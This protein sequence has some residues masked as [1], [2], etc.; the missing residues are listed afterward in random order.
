MPIKTSSLAAMLLVPLAVLAQ[1][2]PVLSITDPEGDDVGDAALVYPRDAAF[3]EGDLDLRS[4]RVFSEG[5]GLRF[6]ATFRNPIRDPKSARA[7]G[8]GS[9]DL[10]VFA[11]HGFYAFNLDI[12]ID[13]D[14]LQ[15]SGNTV[16]L[17]GRRASI[18]PAHA[19]EKVVV[20]TPRPEL[21]KS[22]LIDALKETS[23]T[24]AAEVMASTER[25]VFFATEVRVRG[26]TVSFSVPNS[27]IDAKTLQ[28]SS[29]TAMVTLAKLSIEADLHVFGKSG[30]KPI[31]R[32]TLGVAQPEP[33]RPALAMGYTGDRAPATAIVDLLSP[34]PRQQPLQLAAGGVLTGLNRE[35]RM[36]EAQ[37]IAAPATAPAAAR[38]PTAD[39]GGSWFSRALGTLADMFGVGAGAT[40]AMP[41]SAAGSASPQ[42][43]QSIMAPQAPASAAT[44]APASSA[45]RAPATDRAHPRDQAFFD[46]QEL[47]LRNLERLH[48]SGL[49]TEAEYLRKRKEV[50]DGM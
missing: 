15:G 26:R 45:P 14:R 34:D 8:L 36:G 40:A 24:S 19:W 31:D 4:L 3:S 43:L 1:P 30:G 22:Q 48:K 6:E 21:M 47:R 12:Y 39:A 50:L 46:E 29:L 10:S 33:G 44:S 32:L 35:N 25:S 49:I 7:P 13:T 37:V 23:P 27:F 28:G 42:T 5:S 16:T 9:E 2:T 20:L 41:A 18:D 17:P 38:A 11:R